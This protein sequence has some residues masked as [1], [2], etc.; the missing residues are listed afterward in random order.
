MG[1]VIKNNAMGR[2]FKHYVYILNNYILKQV[3]PFCILFPS[4]EFFIFQL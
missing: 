2:K 3:R 1:T 4:K